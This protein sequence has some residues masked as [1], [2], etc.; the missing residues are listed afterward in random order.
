MMKS[1]KLRLL[2][3]VGV[4]ALAGGLY[5]SA[6]AQVT[7]LPA[8][9]ASSPAPASG[10]ELLA[11][12]LAID[13]LDNGLTIVTAPFASPGTV[14]Y[15]TL[16]RAGSR[17]ETES[18]KSGYAHLFE[19]LMFRGTDKMPAAEYEKRMQAMG[20][21]NNAFTTDDFT[22]YTPT[23]PKDA[24]A[25][26]IGIE[27]D[28]FQHLNV[29]QRAYKDETG[30]VMGEFNKSSSSPYWAMDEALRE[31]AFKRHTYGHTTIGYKRDVEAMPAAYEYSRAFFKRFYTPDDCTIFVVGDFDR[32]KV[33]E[34][35]RANYKD[36]QTKR[37]TTDTRHEP[38][39][40]APRNK[41]LTWKSATTPRLALGWKIPAT[42]SSIKD[43]AA[44][45]VIAALAFGESSDLYQR[46]V[47][48][49]QKAIELSSDP[50][51]VLHRDPGLFRVDVKLKTGTGFDEIVAAIDETLAK[52]G[53]G[54]VPAARIEAVKSHALNGTLLGLQTPNAV[55]ERL[56]FWTAVTGDVRG[57]ETFGK[58]LGTVGAADVARVAKAYLV[59]ARRSVV[60]LSAPSAAAPRPAA[61]KVTAPKPAAPK[62]VVK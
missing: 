3:F 34:L 6:S 28:R 5:G 35:V 31:V 23:I 57:F 8:A 42:H 50:D 12:P 60:T 20:A 54:E 52:L 2:G 15:F 62:A 36:W 61:P 43:A 58:E 49:E 25:E 1:K 45:I 39:Q 18:G 44:L 53:R 7:F 13:K 10:V 41:A 47:V 27:G 40:T 21:D 17:D 24:L 48:N 51:D 14:S 32:A 26:L 56:A 29:A 30:A 55:A 11:Q 22:L 59:P 46:L 38:D 9:P 37:A 16:V 19:H 33:V 4:A